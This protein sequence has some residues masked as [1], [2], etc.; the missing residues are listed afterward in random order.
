[1]LVFSPSVEEPSGKLLLL[2]SDLVR[3]GMRCFLFLVLVVSSVDTP[4]PIR[5]RSTTSR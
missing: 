4:D 3:C 5:L 1:V 2:Y